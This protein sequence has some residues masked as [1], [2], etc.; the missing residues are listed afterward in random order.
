MGIALLGMLECMVLGWLWR[1]GILRHHANSRSDWKLGKWWDYMIRLVIPILLGT[2]FFWQ[3]FDDIN[4]ESGF[5]RTPQGKWILENCVGVGVLVL[6][7]VIAIVFSLVKGRRDAE[8][9]PHE[10][11]VL[12]TRA[13]LG[14]VIALAL[15]LIPAV[16]YIASFN[17][18]TLSLVKNIVLWALLIGGVIS[19]VLS[20]RIVEKCN[21][22]TTQASWLARWAGVLATMDVSAFIAAVLFQLT[23]TVKIREVVPIRNK[24]SGVSYVILAVVFL[25]IVGGLG[26]C[27]YR[28]LAVANLNAETQRPD[29]IDD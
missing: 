1:I 7:P 15:A 27:F 5:L 4:N 28:A 16:L 8:I 24:L 11:R 2:L 21:T 23:R 20:N 26:W 10:E 3:L 6:A 13:R 19:I 25:I 29:Q 22:S 14:G 18:A 17:I 12:E 9:P